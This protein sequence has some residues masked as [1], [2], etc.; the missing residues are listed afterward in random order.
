MLGRFLVVLGFLGGS[1]GGLGG[2]WA[3]LGRLLRGLGR[4]LR[5]SWAVMGR[6]RSFW[7]YV[8]PLGRGIWASKEGQDEAKIGP[9]R[10]QNR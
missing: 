2:S 5:P 10:D 7:S 1:F 3:A 8:F 9:R 6:Q 4:L